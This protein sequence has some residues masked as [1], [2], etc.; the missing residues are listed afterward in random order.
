M[1]RSPEKFVRG[2]LKLFMINLDIGYCRIFGKGA[3]VSVKNSMVSRLGSRVGEVSVKDM[4]SFQ[5][6]RR[7]FFSKLIKSKPMQISVKARTGY[8][9]WKRSV[10]GKLWIEDSHFLEKI[11]AT[12]KGNIGKK[13]MTIG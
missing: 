2:P 10:H 5:E 3:G 6:E 11:F 12:L 4:M 1:E 8:R 9:I 7:E 13:L